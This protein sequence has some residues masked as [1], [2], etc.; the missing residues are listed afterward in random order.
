[1]QSMLPLK[2]C[3]IVI[4]ASSWVTATP[5]QMPAV[6][7]SDVNTHSVKKYETFEI[8]LELSAVD[9]QNPYDPHDI[10]VCTPNSSHLQASPCGSMAF[11][12]TTR[13]QTSGNSVFRPM[14]L[15]L[16]PIRSS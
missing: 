6:R 3:V 9:I 13:V 16:G 5:A 10:D 2:L 15:A 4:V 1:M 11:M 8:K 7:V 12:T 14:G